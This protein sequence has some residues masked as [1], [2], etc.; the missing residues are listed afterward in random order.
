MQINKKYLSITTL[1]ALSALMAQGSSIYQNSH[2]NLVVD[3]SAFVNFS[4]N[5]EALRSDNRLQV[6]GQIEELDK[7][8]E[9]V[10]V[11]E[12]EIEAGNKHSLLAL[13]ISP[14]TTRSIA[15]S[16]KKIPEI[17]SLK[18]KI[19][20]TE[21]NN[22][23]ITT[24][25]I[26][27]VK[28]HTPI[29]LESLVI[30]LIKEK[31]VALNT[32]GVMDTQ[33]YEINNAE[34]IKAQVFSAGVGSRIKFSELSIEDSYGKDVKDEVDIG[35]SATLKSKNE[36]IHADEVRTIQHSTKKED[37]E[38][39][40]LQVFDYSTSEKSEYSPKGISDTVRRAI[41]REMTSPSSKATPKKTNLNENLGEIDLNSPD[42]IVYDYSKDMSSEQPND[43]IDADASTLTSSRNNTIKLKP[44]M[45]YLNT[46]RIAK[47]VNSEFASDYDRS[48]VINESSP[49]EITIDYSSTGEL[50]THTGVIRAEG[51][52]PT[53]IEI[54]V[55][56]D[57][58]LNVPLL[59]ES[60]IDKFFQA[61]GVMR[62]GNL[63]MFSV[64]TDV[65]DVEIDTK[66]NQKIYL[67]KDLKIQNSRQG[68]DYIV[69]SG[70]KSG[71]VL[72]SYLLEKG[73][74]AQK[75]VYVGE[76]EMYF[77][78]ANITSS[79]RVTVG[80]TSRNIM[81]L[82]QKGLSLDPEK[83][84]FFAT[85]ITAKKKALSAYEFKIPN[86]PNG[87]RKYLELKNFKEPVF[88][89]FSEQKQLEIPTREFIELV[90]EK[91]KISDLGERCLV[92]INLSKDIREIK[93]GGKN[94]TGEMDIQTMFLDKDGN[95][96]SESPEYSE[97]AFILGDLEGLISAKIEYVNGSSEYLKTFC[98]EGS[99]IVEQL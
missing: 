53:R 72:V 45:V 20:A 6:S 32:Q 15:S 66:L 50:N 65:L 39:D 77:E 26:G 43:S 99:Y 31:V 90:L 81:G 60:G 47:G 34:V 36:S 63:M 18:T 83:L 71:N 68:A 17:E 84:Q 7:A 1:V 52:I 91:N 88:V 67:N 85:N 25:K 98:S 78:H 10:N 74:R 82:V 97:K 42:N 28:K 21:I 56:S 73:D 55:N 33:K 46:G 58:T 16:S 87:M 80:L 9:I 29:R 44:I 2:K 4:N 93:V 14:K 24:S 22:S 49:G 27:S 76:G 89:G 92:Q 19:S 48:E 69:L 57:K 61:Q 40:D 3:Y 96:S 30:E 12:S 54:N 79:S 37:V 62:E 5:L 64:P 38:E 23:E 94:R 8:Q 41:K 95:F 35:Q 75:V 70:V 59:A 86:L 13:G 11:I 51:V